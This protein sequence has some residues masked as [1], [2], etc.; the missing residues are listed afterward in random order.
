MK[1]AFDKP[2]NIVFKP[3]EAGNTSFRLW[4][5]LLNFSEKSIFALF[6]DQ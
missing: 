4:D 2:K 1:I 3:V 5:D 6:C